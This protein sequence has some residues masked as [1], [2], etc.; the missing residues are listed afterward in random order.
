MQTDMR[1]IKSNEDIVLDGR[2][3]CI[4]DDDEL[5]RGYLAA[6]L[7]QRNLVVLEAPDANGLQQVLDRRMP[8][9]LL[10]DYNLASENGL[11][12]LERLKLRYPS[13]APIIMVSA[14]ETQ[15]TAVR[16]FRSGIADFVCKR[17]LKLEEI[18]GA[19]RRAIA[20]RVRDEV[21]EKEVTRLREHAKFDELTGIHL[22]A[23]LEERLA[24]IA[25]TARRTRRHYGIVAFRLTRVGEVQERFGVVAAD[26]VLRAFGQKL[27][28]HLRASDL[29]GVYDRGTCLYVVDTDPTPE[30]L[31]LLAQ[32]V[33]PRLT[34]DLDISAAHVHLEAVSARVLHP[35]DGDA[36]A[37]LIALLERRV[38]K[39]TDEHLQNATSATDWVRTPSATEVK[40]GLERR[41]EPR[42]RTLKQGRI[43]LNGLQSTIDCTVRNLSSGGASLRLHGPTALPELFR[44][45][46]SDGGAV[47]RVR[48]CWH[49]NNDVGVEFLPD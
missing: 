49:F 39:A 36:L 3:V 1:D 2:Q 30:A 13:L 23:G 24:T 20:L 25:E 9:C 4:V 43:F 48:K 46:I 16:A 42:L 14:D 44:L 5:F 32:R 19:V 28:E 34:V 10:M 6:L 40:A 26:R 31:D 45:K 8:D 21:R 12:I 7:A 11:F 15:R 22:R 38:D 33:T 35:D 41:R 17:N 18:V 29:C 47:R 27:R 37:D